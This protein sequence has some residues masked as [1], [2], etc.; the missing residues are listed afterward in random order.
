MTGPLAVSIVRTTSEA[1]TDREFPVV[2]GMARWGLTRL[3]RQMH[4]SVP[5]C[6]NGAGLTAFAC[7]VPHRDRGVVPRA[8]L[9]V[10]LRRLDGKRADC[11][12]TGWCT[13]ALAVAALSL[14]GMVRATPLPLV[15]YAVAIDAT[16]S[17]I[18]V[19]ACAFTKPVQLPVRHALLRRQLLAEVASAA[20]GTLVQLDGD[21]LHLAAGSCLDYSVRIADHVRGD[22][23]DPTARVGADLITSPEH[24]LPLPALSVDDVVDVDFVLPPGVH[25]STAW[26]RRDGS[27]R[28]YRIAASPGGF[29]AVVAFGRFVVEP[30]H[31]GGA[32]LAVAVLDGHPRPDAQALV[33]WVQATA[34][35]V[36]TVTPRFPVPTLQVVVTPVL[37][38]GLFERGGAVVPMARVLRDG[39]NGLQIYVN[40]SA[41]VTALLSDPTASHEFAHL[42]LPFVER[43]GAWLSEGMASYYQNV[44]RARAGII[45]TETAFRN[46]AAGFS[47]GRGNRRYA[48]TLADSIRA[49]GDNVVMRTYWSGAAIALMVDVALRTRDR[50]GSLPASSL[51]AV[52][53][54]FVACCLPSARTWTAEEVTAKFDALSG[55]STFA[56]LADRWLHAREFPDPLPAWSRLGISVGPTQELVF[57]PAASAVAL[58]AAIMG[59]RRN[60]ALFQ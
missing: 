58:R 12:R 57:D 52:L 33:R 26:Q 54:Q 49:N 10:L 43:Q 4:A 23:R 15:G 9:S 11:L 53:A 27:G 38:N 18:D 51:D 35:Q 30:V 17:I 16:L 6:A 19:R 8:W 29:R 44:L 25:V 32:E 56:L 3:L 41:D 20:G 42:L 13:S 28:R 31:V 46:L 37:G 7:G 22:G 36:V 59:A 5:R 48:L 39:G 2:T 47:R 14:A 55:G 50:D 1:W 40:Q 24:W 21:T 34:A 45:T 60:S